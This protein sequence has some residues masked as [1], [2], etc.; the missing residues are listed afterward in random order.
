M[1]VDTSGSMSLDS[2]DI[3]RILRRAPMETLVAIYSGASDRG[4]L[5]IVARGGRHADSE[6]LAPFGRGNIVDLPALKWLGQQPGP[7][8][9]ISDGGVTGV[10]DTGSSKIKRS[11]G[12]VCSSR[13]I[14]RVK[15][16]EEAATLLA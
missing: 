4:E 8:I 16:V 13:R 11:C 14:Q 6:H 2:D 7:R 5:R 9:W 15:T 12:E 3:R 10:G 1:L